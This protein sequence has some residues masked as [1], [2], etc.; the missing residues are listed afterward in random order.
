LNFLITACL[1]K[2]KSGKI[3]SNPWYNPASGKLYEARILQG[4]DMMAFSC[5]ESFPAFPYFRDWV[6]YIRME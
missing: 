3:Y 2:L 1:G 5:P 4:S 6:L